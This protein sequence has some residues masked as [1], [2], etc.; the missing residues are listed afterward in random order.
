MEI[1]NLHTMKIKMNKITGTEKKLQIGVLGCSRVAKRYFFPYISSS[2]FADVGFIGSRSLEKAQQYAKDYGVTK[3]GS[4]EDVVNSDVDIIY[5]SLPISM[6]EEWCIKSAKAG[7]HILCEKSSTTSYESAKKILHVC[8][9]N[10]VRI[11]EA[12]AFRFHPQHKS[13]KNLINNELG[14]INNFYGIFGFSP[15]DEHDIRWQKELGGGVLN[16]VTCY[17]ICASRIIF[18]SEPLSVL[19]YFEYDKKFGVEKYANAL[20]KYSNQKTAFI[21][22]GYGNYYQSKYSIWGSNAKISTKRA[23]SVPQDYEA[24]IFLDKNDEIIETTVLPADQFGIM[25]DIFCNVVTK[26]ITNPFDFEKDLL[27]QAKLME[28][29]RISQQEN[30]VVLLSEFD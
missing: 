11:L 17:P 12:F 2:E 29:I 7:K 26:K 24:S 22:S 6:H 8:K 10:N 21:S 5:I 23:Y 4:Y 25:C 1:L 28:S 30:R 20:L 16:D 13:I 15:P 27:N 9:E 19:A 14:E 3:Y 18:N